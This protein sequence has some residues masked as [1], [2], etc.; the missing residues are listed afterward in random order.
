G[1]VERCLGRR[2]ARPAVGRDGGE[3]RLEVTPEGLG[4]VEVH[5]VVREDAVH[6]SLTAQHDHVRAALAAER[7][8]L[9]QALERANLRLEGFNVGLGHEQASSR[10]PHDEAGA[11]PSP[12]A[13]AAPI[14]PTAPNTAVRPALRGGLSLVA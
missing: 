3:M 6:A 1:G 9:A 2:T 10:A 4:R 5:V 7:P 14:T 12:R 11:P 8:A 13:T